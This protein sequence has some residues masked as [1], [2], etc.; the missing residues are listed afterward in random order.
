MANDISNRFHDYGMASEESKKYTKINQNLIDLATYISENLTDSRETS[1]VLTKLEE[2]H[3]W[4]KASIS[5]NGL[6]I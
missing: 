4:L 6:N 3:F 5:R 1:M 2:A